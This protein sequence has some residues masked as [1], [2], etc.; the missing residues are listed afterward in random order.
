ML[1][2]LHSL[3]CFCQNQP[4]MKLFKAFFAAL[5][6]TTLTLG[7]MAQTT[8]TAAKPKSEQTTEKKSTEKKPADGWTKTGDKINKALKGPNGE[9]VYL[10]PKGSNYYLDKKGNKVYLK[11]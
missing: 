8:S 3:Y 5:L 2:F 11:K 6:A 1:Q 7:T 10:G 4:N 9:T